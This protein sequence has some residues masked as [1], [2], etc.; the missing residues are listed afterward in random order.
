[1]LFRK[2]LFNFRFLEKD[3]LANHRIVLPHLELFGR[4][5]GILLGDVV[6]P[7]AR[8]AN[9]ANLNGARLRHWIQS[10]NA[11]LPV[12]KRRHNSGDIFQVKKIDVIIRRPSWL[13]GP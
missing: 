12:F 11:W 13:P 10:L 5:P 6:I 2:R 7:R 4:V 3:M 8:G 1:M 9:E